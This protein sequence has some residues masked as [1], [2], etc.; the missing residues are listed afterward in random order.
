MTR[1]GR[2]AQVSMQPAVWRAIR[3]QRESWGARTRGSQ[4]AQVGQRRSDG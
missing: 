4:V 3:R 1:K 2:N